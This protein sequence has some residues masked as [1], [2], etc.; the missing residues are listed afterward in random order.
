MLHFYRR[1]EIIILVLNKLNCQMIK[2]KN[3]ILTKDNLKELKDKTETIDTVK[4][5]NSR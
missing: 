1:M 5:I 2:I 3:F 4:L